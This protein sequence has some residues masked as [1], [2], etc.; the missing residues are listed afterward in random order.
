MRFFLGLLMATFVISGHASEQAVVGFWASETSIFEI[1]VENETLS[2]V[3]VALRNPNYLAEEGTGR[4]GLPRTDDNNPEDEM[5]ALPIM[6]LSMFSEYVYESESWQGKIYDPE[7]GNTYQS[8]M[9]INADEELEIRGYIG[10]PMF[11]RTAKFMPLSRCSEA[12]I[13]MLPQIKIESPCM[14]P[15]ES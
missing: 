5:Q 15:Q 10:M 9:K 13:E 7:S 1:R 11:G 12:I 3:V 4:T 14:V 6:G 2:G 8:K